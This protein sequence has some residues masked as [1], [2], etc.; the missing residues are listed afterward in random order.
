MGQTVGCSGTPPEPGLV[1]V[2]APDGQFL[3]IGQVG[4][5]DAARPI[6]KPVRLFNDLGSNPT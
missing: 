5:S 6:L 2:Y 4:V 3:G 1:R